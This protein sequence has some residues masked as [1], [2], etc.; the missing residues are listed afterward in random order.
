MNADSYKN[1]RLPGEFAPL[2]RAYIPVQEAVTPAY[3]SSEAL[4]RGTLFPGLDLPFMNIVN[5]E[6]DQTPLTELMAI[7]F[8]TDELELYLDTHADDS[9]A[10]AL[11]Q[12][13]LALKKEAHER[14]AERCGVISQTDMLGMDSYSWLKDPWP[15][16]FQNRGG[17]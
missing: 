15:W 17:N 13:F 8:V 12:T 3:E 16:D 14:Y 9:E 2:A 7:D 11:Y 4:S 6:L 5:D 10:F 1:G